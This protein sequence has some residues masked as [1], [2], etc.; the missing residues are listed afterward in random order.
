MPS[1]N[2]SSS[3]S[4]SST[5]GLQPSVTVCEKE[6][7]EL[8]TQSALYRCKNHSI[9]ISIFNT[10]QESISKIADADLSSTV[11]RFFNYNEIVHLISWSPDRLHF[12]QVNDAQVL[13]GNGS[14]FN[15]L[16]VKYSE[17]TNSNK[18]TFLK[19]NEDAS[20]L[21]VS[22]AGLTGHNVFT[23]V[24]EADDVV[25]ALFRKMISEKK[26][27]KSAPLS[28]PRTAH[29]LFRLEDGRLL[30]P[31]GPNVGGGYRKDQRESRVL[32]GR[33]SNLWQNVYRIYDSSLQRSGYPN[34]TFYGDC[35]I[36]SAYINLYP[37]ERATYVEEGV[38]KTMVAIR[39]PE[40]QIGAGFVPIADPIVFNTPG[41]VTI[42]DLEECARFCS[43]ESKEAKVYKLIL[44]FL[45]SKHCLK[46]WG[47]E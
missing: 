34:V 27:I 32:I 3:S 22:R 2:F 17:A 14:Q 16:L 31:F 46:Q 44:E 10:F 21:T 25:I 12:Q 30:L 33:V 20:K 38:T 19:T 7:K 4:S 40:D 35:P 42:D 18:E 47:L 11:K 15:D 24:R 26:T 36:S 29:S 13:C 39:T 8:A 37:G 41:T 1:V 43:K 9:L 23:F 45:Y 28:F 6:L 5:S